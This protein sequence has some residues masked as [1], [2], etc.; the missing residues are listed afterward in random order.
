MYTPTR[1]VLVR[2]KQPNQRRFLT[3]VHA[4]CCRPHAGKRVDT[5]SSQGMTVADLTLAQQL[6]DSV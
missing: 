1:V 5:S 3:D 6:D 4:P 2:T